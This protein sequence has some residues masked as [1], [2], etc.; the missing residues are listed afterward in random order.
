MF[1]TDSGCRVTVCGRQGRLTAQFDLDSNW[2]SR[3]TW[4]INSKLHGRLQFQS[5][6]SARSVSLVG[7][8][9]TFC[10]WGERHLILPCLILGRAS[11]SPCPSA[12]PGFCF[13][14]LFLSRWHISVWIISLVQEAA[15]PTIFMCVCARLPAR[16]CTRSPVS[17]PSSRRLMSARPFESGDCDERGRGG[18]GWRREGWMRESGEWK[19]VFSAARRCVRDVAFARG[20]GR[21]GLVLLP[22]KEPLWVFRRSGWGYFCS[23]WLFS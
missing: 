7:S 4:C 22:L 1:Q 2:Y 21:A 17:L 10:R 16:T 11:V 19:G 9:Y 8:G 14:V 3:S 6:R 20:R 23:Q 5:A 18:E 15:A 13:A 12:P